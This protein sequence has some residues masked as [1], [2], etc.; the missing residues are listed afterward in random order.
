[1]NTLDFGVDHPVVDGIAKHITFLSS[2]SVPG[3]TTAEVAKYVADLADAFAKQISAQR[4]IMIS[5]LQ[6]M[7][8]YQQSVQSGQAV[9]LDEETARF[10]AALGY[11]DWP[12][13]GMSELLSSSREQL[14][15]ARYEWYRAE[16]YRMVTQ[17]QLMIELTSA[18]YALALP[19]KTQD[20]Q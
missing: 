17:A 20:A 16:I 11:E 1:M 14:K 12:E 6:I 9:Q 15:P 5:R 7:H 2:G 4:G 10:C 19:Q 8:A 3:L 18:D 13:R